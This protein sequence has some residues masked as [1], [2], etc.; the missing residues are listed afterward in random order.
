ML[1]DDEGG[2]TRSYDKF[3]FHFNKKSIKKNSG[4]SGRKLQIK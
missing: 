4:K 2:F 1:D 3:L